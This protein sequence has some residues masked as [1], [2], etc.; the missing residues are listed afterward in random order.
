MPR[1]S[2][3]ICA[4]ALVA[5]LVAPSVASACTIPFRKIGPVKISRSDLRKPTFRY[6]TATA[7]KVRGDFRSVRPRLTQYVVAKG[8]GKFFGHSYPKQ[9]ALSLDARGPDDRRWMFLDDNDPETLPCQITGQI[10]WTA[11]EFKVKET[12]KEVRILAVSYRNPNDATGCHFG[13]EMGYKGCPNL[14]RRV[15]KLKNP[16]GKRKIVFEEFAGQPADTV[17]DD[18][19]V[20]FG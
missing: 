13:F 6:A 17:S 2:H 8:I 12:K 18:T 3:R 1:R 14:T 7:W 5:L 9:L 11:P 16:V 15:L 4:L 19:P 10:M 20:T